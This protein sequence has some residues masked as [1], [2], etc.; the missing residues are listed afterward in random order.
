[1]T[2]K[3]QYMMNNPTIHLATVRMIASVADCE[4]N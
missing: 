3:A 1:M 4:G 2:G